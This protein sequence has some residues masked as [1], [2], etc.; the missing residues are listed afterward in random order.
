LTLVLER[1]IFASMDRSSREPSAERPISN[2]TVAELRDLLDTSLRGERPHV[3]KITV[4]SAIIS[5]ALRRNGMEATL[6]GGGAI[7]FHASDVYS[8]NDIDLVVEGKS[9]HDALRALAS[10][11]APVTETRLQ[12]T[13]ERLTSP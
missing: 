10:E 7:E 4:A 13:L 2:P 3:E 9:R 11:N 12:E 8:T 5:E 1:P 6:V